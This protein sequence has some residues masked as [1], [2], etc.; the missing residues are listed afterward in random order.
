MAMDA[1]T[2][3]VKRDV[4]PSRKVALRRQIF[5]SDFVVLTQKEISPLNSVQLQKSRRK[6]KRA[7]VPG[8][9]ALGG[10]CY[11]N[12]RQAGPNRRNLKKSLAELHQGL[13]DY[14][15]L[16]VHQR[17]HRTQLLALLNRLRVCHDLVAP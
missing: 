12:P 8:T 10:C 2:S 4:R 7:A 11:C 16:L 13:Y 17:L 6:R 15:R 14:E 9:A 3:L 5:G 1:R